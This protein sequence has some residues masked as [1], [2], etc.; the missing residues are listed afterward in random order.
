MKKAI[1]LILLFSFIFLQTGKSI[2]ETPT[3]PMNLSVISF[4]S[5]EISDKLAEG[6]LFTNLTGSELN[7]QYP[8]LAGSFDNNAT[9][10]YNKTNQKTEYWVYVSGNMLVDICQGAKYNLCSN[11]TCVGPG[12]YEIY[13]S[14]VTWNSSKINDAQN[15]SLLNS[16]PMVLGFDNNNK[17]TQI[18]PGEYVYLRY[19]LD[20]PPNF[21]PYN[22]STIYQVQA[23]PSGGT[24]V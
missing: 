1:F 18:Q 24:C 4:Y 17:I 3:L 2:R 7:V 21:P 11:L 22:Y 5:I 19:W 23:V 9:F 20:V 13:I 12:N 15:P 14:N 16:I 8:L 10:N 6:I